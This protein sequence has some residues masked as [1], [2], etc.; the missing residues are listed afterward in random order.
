MRYF[1]ALLFFSL[2][3]NAFSQ[4]TNPSKKVYGTI[5][6]STTT[7]PLPNVNI[8]NVNK[9]RGTISN[10]RGNFEIDAEVNDTLHIT[11]IGF[12]SLR[13]R[14]TNDWIKNGNAK[15]ELTEKAIA[16]EEVRVR[17]YWIP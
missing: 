11:M 14:V 17:K 6:N 1:V 15:I 13:V 8:I 3:I 4:Q 5:I 16:L 2:S 12:Q 7:F 9:V 10:A